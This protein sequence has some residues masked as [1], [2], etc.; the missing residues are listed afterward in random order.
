MLAINSAVAS[1]PDVSQSA[2]S[3]APTNTGSPLVCSG[4]ERFSEPQPTTVART[5][6]SDTNIA[7]GEGSGAKTSR[8]LLRLRALNGQ[9]I[10]K[11]SL[12]VPNSTFGTIYNPFSSY[13]S[14]Y[15]P[16]CLEGFFSATRIHTLAYQ[17]GTGAYGDG[18]FV[19]GAS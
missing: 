10:S 15:S 19:H 16:S 8:E 4:A 14:D 17:Y 3:P 7:Y 11:P 18:A 9:N 5:K 12:H 2:M 13:R 6:A 1:S